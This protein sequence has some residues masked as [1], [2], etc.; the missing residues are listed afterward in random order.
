MLQD[1]EERYSTDFG[2]Q[3]LREG[4]RPLGFCWPFHTVS[5]GPHTLLSVSGKT[6]SLDLPQ[7]SIAEVGNIG[8]H[9]S[10]G[11]TK[12]IKDIIILFLGSPH[13]AAIW[14]LYIYS[15]HV[16]MSPPPPSMTMT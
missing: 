6:C 14:K 1:K 2:G 5:Q 12:G 3:G 13:E 15:F 10:D 7:G 16:Y 8:S 9:S 11:F 4:E